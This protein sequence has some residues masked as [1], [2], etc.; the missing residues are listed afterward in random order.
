MPKPP[1]DA[2]VIPPQRNTIRRATMYVPMMPQVMP[3][4]T[5]AISA[6]DR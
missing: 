1:N 4:S 2:C 3:E 5:Q 6:F